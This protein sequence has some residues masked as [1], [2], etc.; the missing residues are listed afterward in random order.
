MA[1]DTQLTPLQLGQALTLLS[2]SVRELTTQVIELR[3]KVEDLT[4]R[5]ERDREE[6]RTFARDAKQA[7]EESASSR[8]QELRAARIDT[9]L[10]PPPP[11]RHGRT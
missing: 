10:P 5:Y 1:D 6:I 2:G 9:P 8:S 4:Q 7:L 11:L 3:A